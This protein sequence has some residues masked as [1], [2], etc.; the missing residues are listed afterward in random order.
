M[1]ALAMSFPR[2]VRDSNKINGLRNRL[3]KNGFIDLQGFSGMKKTGAGQRSRR[4][5]LAPDRRYRATQ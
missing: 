1:P 2:E 3:G 4:R 5:N